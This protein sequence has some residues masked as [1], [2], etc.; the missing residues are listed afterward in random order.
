MASR[1]GEAAS[2][3]ARRLRSCS[4]AAR[5]TWVDVQ[6]LLR[7][8]TARGICLLP[9]RRIAEEVDAPIATVEELAS[10]GVLCGSDSDGASFSWAPTH[11]G[12]RGDA[13][14][15]V[16]VASGACWYCPAIVVKDH[17]S[18]LKSKATRKWRSSINSDKGSASPFTG[19]GDLQQRS[20]NVWA[21][22]D[23]SAR[24]CL[25]MRRAGVRGSI[26]NHP[27][28][29]AAIAEGG[30][31]RMF[32]E[33]AKEAALNGKGFVWAVAQV[34]ARLEGAARSASRARAFVGGVIE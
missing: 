1:P 30:T 18:R 15:L 25:S 32:D 34:R 20:I 27:S 17:S 21:D 3:S 28:L 31:E 33:A 16:A 11:A 23:A 8:Q 9:L 22:P 29:L 19:N 5:G 10:A 13:V 24:V 2:R 26:P 4:R 6:E 14:Q 7:A 12:K